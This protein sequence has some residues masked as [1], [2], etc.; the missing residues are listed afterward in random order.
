M[1][2]VSA[3]IDDTEIVAVDLQSANV[4]DMKKMTI[5]LIPQIYIFA[6]FCTEKANFSLF[7]VVCLCHY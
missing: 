5:A 3:I 6:A 7:D 2:S 1:L 4:G